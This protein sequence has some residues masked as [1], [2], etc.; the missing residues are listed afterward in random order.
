LR[1]CDLV[2]SRG[3]DPWGEVHRVPTGTDADTTRRRH[4]GVPVPRPRDL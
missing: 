4:S 2:P 3:T 1:R